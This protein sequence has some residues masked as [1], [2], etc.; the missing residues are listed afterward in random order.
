MVSPISK[1][2]GRWLPGWERKERR[3]TASQ[4]ARHGTRTEHARNTRAHPAVYCQPAQ[5]HRVATPSRESAQAHSH[6]SDIR[7]SHSPGVPPGPQGTP[8]NSSGTLLTEASRQRVPILPPLPRHHARWPR[9][10]EPS[11]SRPCARPSRRGRPCTRPAG[12]GCSLA[13]R[14]PASW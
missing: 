14:P 9:P 13:G 10:L 3:R 1:A 2:T 7:A 8:R 12:C 11:R 5:C 4:D 6:P